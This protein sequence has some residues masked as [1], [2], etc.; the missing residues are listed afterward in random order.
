MVTTNSII[1]LGIIDL[2]S[3]VSFPPREQQTLTGNY[4]ITTSLLKLRKSNSVVM[5]RENVMARHQH[6]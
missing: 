3:V 1:V 5:S 6:C 4:T 2:T